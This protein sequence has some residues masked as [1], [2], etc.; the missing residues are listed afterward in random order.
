M[1]VRQGREVGRDQHGMDRQ[2][3]RID[4]LGAAPGGEFGPVVAV[5]RA[6]R[7][8]DGVAR[9]V[10]GDRDGVGQRPVQHGDQFRGQMLAA[11]QTPHDGQG[12]V[13]LRCRVRRGKDVRVRQPWLA[14]VLASPFGCGPGLLAI[15]GHTGSGPMVP[16]L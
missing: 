16:R 15:L 4:M 12:V 14:R 7:F 3:G 11:C 9:V 8:G 6:G 5:G 10:G 13:F 2:D 1:F